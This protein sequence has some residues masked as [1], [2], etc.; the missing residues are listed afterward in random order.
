ML[1]GTSC[2]IRNILDF[3]N[4]SPSHY[5]PVTI[6]AIL[7]LFFYRVGFDSQTMQI[8]S[9]AKLLLQLSKLVSLTEVQVFLKLQSGE[10]HINAYIES[11]T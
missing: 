8:A 2:S 10:K 4:A 5:L 9:N 6:E 7:F 1:C 11:V 3:S